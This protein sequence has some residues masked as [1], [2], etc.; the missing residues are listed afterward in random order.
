MPEDKQTWFKNPLEVDVAK[1]PAMSRHI[2]GAAVV[3]D[4][5]SKTTLDTELPDVKTVDK[6]LEI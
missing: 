6:D 3:A 4:S 2:F 1:A 5:V